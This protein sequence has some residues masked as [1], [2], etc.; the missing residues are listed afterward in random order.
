MLNPSLVGPFDTISV[1]VV[2]QEYCLAMC[3]RELSSFLGRVTDWF[4]VFNVSEAVDISM[5]VN[6]PIEL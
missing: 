1:K 2:L 4:I 3:F 6:R 5:Q